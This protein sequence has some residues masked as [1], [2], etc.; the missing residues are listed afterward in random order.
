MTQPPYPPPPGY[1][2]PGQPMTQPQGYPGP[3]VAV[4][5]A[6]PPP[7]AAALPALPQGWEWGPGNVPRPVQAAPV[8]AVAPPPPVAY[9]GMQMPGAAPV[10]YAPPNGGFPQQSIAHLGAAIADATLGVTRYPQMTPGEYLLVLELSKKPERSIAI[11]AEFTVEQSTSLDRPPGTRV[12]WYQDLSGGTPEKS[13]A[14][15]GAALSMILRTTGF[16]T[17]EACL[18]SGWT[19]E[20]LAAHINACFTGP[21]PLVGRRVRVVVTNSGKL[22]KAKQD[23]TGGGLPIM[24]YLWSPA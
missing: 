11:V 9:G 20:A 12:S 15:K 3:S 16:P 2:M 5:V 24:N 1:P 13:E 14:Q 22:T 4:P 23:G 8:A 6:P 19:K 18:G 21:G 7:A 17:P 10:G